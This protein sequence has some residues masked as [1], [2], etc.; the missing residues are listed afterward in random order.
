MR[1]VSVDEYVQYMKRYHLYWERQYWKENKPYEATCKDIDIFKKWCRQ[2]NV[3]QFCK[4]HDTWVK[5]DIN[6]RERPGI[7]KTPLEDHAELFRNANK[8][9][10]FVTQPYANL[11]MISESGLNTYCEKRGLKYKVSEELSWHYPKATILIQYTIK[12]KD[13]FDNYIKQF[14]VT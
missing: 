6:K 12:V 10:I 3:I 9:M 13:I 7:D 5:L 11:K 4:S 2:Y 1:F 8:E 14:K